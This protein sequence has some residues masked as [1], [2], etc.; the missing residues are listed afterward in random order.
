MP[1]PQALTDFNA[2]EFGQT[3]IDDGEARSVL[4]LQDGPGSFAIHGKDRLQSAG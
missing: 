4:F 3:E 1:R 2:I